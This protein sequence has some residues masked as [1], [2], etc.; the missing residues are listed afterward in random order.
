MASAAPLSDEMEFRRIEDVGPAWQTVALSNSYNSAVPVCIYVTASTA[1]PS[2]LPRIRNI[3][4][5]SFELKIQ[6]M[7]GGS[8]PVDNPTPGTVHCVVAET[9][10]HTLADGRTFEAF[11]VLSDRT[12]GSANGGWNVADFENVSASVSGS[13]TSPVALVGLVTSNDPQPTAPFTNDCDTRGNPPF[14]SGQADGICVGKHTGQISTTRMNET[15][16]VI[17]AEAGSGTSNDI[18]Y[19]FFRGADS[20]NGIGTNSNTGYSVSADFDSATATQGGEDGGQGGWATL[21]GSDP[22]ANGFIRISV[23]EEVVAGDTSRTHVNEIF[24][25][26]AFRDDRPVELEAEKTQ[27]VWDPSGVGAYSLPGQDIAYTLTVRNASSGPTDADTIFLVDRI[28]D[29]MEFYN[30]DFDPFDADPAPV[31]FSDNA[32]GLTFSYSSDVGYSASPGRPSGM[33]Q[34]TYTPAPGYDPNVRHV[35]L[36]PGGAM[37]AGTPS[38]EASFSFRGRIR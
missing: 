29:E 36:A 13:Y 31:L 4:S 34:C 11:T 1:S 32:S 10:L 3:Q 9:G 35:C 20:P 14:F 22:L 8:N 19:N 37:A 25:V 17:I 23:D 2:A 28:P 7:T 6:E 5:D 12:T 18:F 21:V 15:I 24:D 16:G 30:G 33:A 38:P 26:F 27:A